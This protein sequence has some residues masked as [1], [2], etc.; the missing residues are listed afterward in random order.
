MFRAL[1]ATNITF[2]ITSLA[3]DIWTTSAISGSEVSIE[4]INLAV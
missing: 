4:T 2:G 3:V 1:V